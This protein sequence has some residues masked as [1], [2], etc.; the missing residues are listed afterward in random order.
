MKYWADKAHKLPLTCTVVSPDIRWVYSASK[1]AGLVVRDLQTGAREFRVVGGRSGQQSYHPGHC[2]LV[3]A[4]GDTDKLHTFKRHRAAVLGLAF[5]RGTHTLYSA[6]R[7]CS[8]KIWSVDES[9]LDCVALL[10]EEHW[11][12]AGEDGHLA[13]WGIYKKSLAMVRTT[14]F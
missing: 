4:T 6:S 3:L 10:N 8:V 7:D 5:R 13:V 11:A 14:L 1:D 2:S 9:S 12:T